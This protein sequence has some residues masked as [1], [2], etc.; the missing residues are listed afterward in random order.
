[1]RSRTLLVL[2]A[3]L[4]LALSACNL[5]ATEVPPTATEIVLPSE[6]TA[7]TLASTHTPDPTALAPTETPEPSDTPAPLDTATPTP[8]ATEPPLAPE[9][10]FGSPTLQDEMNNDGN[11]ASTSGGLPNTANI[12]LAVGGGQLHVTAKQAGFDTWWFTWPTAGDQFIQMTIDSGN[13][14]D[15]AAYG[16]ILRGPSD[17][18]LARGYVVLLSCDG[19]Y[20]L[21]RLDSV[22]PYTLVDLIPWTDSERINAG[23]GQVNVLGVHAQGDVIRIYANGF[24]V[25]E[26]EDDLYSTGRFGL[27]TNAGPATN[28]LWHLDQL[29]FWNLD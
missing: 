3:L 5:G 8:T 21:A 19:A 27:F 1:M 22:S 24:K 28:F 13:C 17:V 6:T 14:S 25:G 16:L 15:K 20:R 26:H 29:L 23:A 7:A 10:E 9:A 4:A 12:L 2:S 18:T 11:W